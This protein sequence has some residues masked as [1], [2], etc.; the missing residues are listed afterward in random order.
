MT[1][2]E[3]DGMRVFV[4]GATGAVGSRLLPLLVAAGHS[5]VELT[6]SPAKAE[7]IR[8]AGGEAAVGDALNR[9]AIVAAVAGARPEVIVHEMTSLRAANDL[10]RADRAF[11][12]TNRL[13]QEGLDNLP[14]AARQ[15]GTARLVAQ[16]FCG[17]PYERSGGAVKTEDD[18]L[19]RAPPRAL[20]PTLEAIRYLEERVT[21][22]SQIA[23]IVLRYG[24]FYGRGTGLFDGPMIDRLRRR[25]VPL[26]GAAQGWWSF[27]HIDDAAAATGI[28][29]ERGAAG[30]YNIVD[31]E[32][33]P[34]DAWLPALAAMLGAKPPRRVPT[35][36]ARIAAGE[37][38]A[39]LTTEARAG[40]N[41]K[42]KRELALN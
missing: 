17:W 30:I 35:W 6:R 3:A 13:R 18:P 1:E 11:A 40:S 10:R 12:L 2:L 15:A 5:V 26:I 29:I 33:A 16:S 27:L 24:A 38:I 22:S 21:A 25:R 28:A 19:D 32:P 42:A 23:G 39:M 4:A 34:V 8:R 41:A 31:D 14:A 7:A 9:A 36:L 37:H 20:R